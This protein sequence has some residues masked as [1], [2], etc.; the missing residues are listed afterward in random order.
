[1]KVKGCNSKLTP[2]VLIMIAAITTLI[3]VPLRTYQLVS[4]VEPK[5]GFY[6]KYDASIVILYVVLG[7][8]VLSLFIMSFL[9]ATLP[10]P[11]IPCKRNTVLGAMSVILAAGFFCDFGISID[12]FIRLIGSVTGF[13]FQYFVKSG[14]ITILIQ[15]IFAL[16]SGIY[17]IIFGA[18]A[19]KGTN[20]YEKS[21]ALA[22]SPI[23]WGL[24]RI[25]HRFIEPISFK[26]VSELVIQLFMI[27][28][29]LMFFMSFAR[30]ASRVN[31]TESCW[32]LYGAGLSSAILLLTDVFSNAIVMMVGKSEIL[33]AKYQVNM[34]DAFIAIFIFVLLIELMPKK[35]VIEQIRNNNIELVEETTDDDE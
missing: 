20:R 23:V 24:A 31:H 32:V 7:L 11:E 22:L 5:T 33:Y 4:L 18:S 16:L 35:S 9:C 14:C 2:K 8:A 28:I 27:S 17:F 15:L 3:A 21:R 25:I 12:S 29:L 13:R 6:I 26:N 34:A 1:M 10:R 19:I 30:I